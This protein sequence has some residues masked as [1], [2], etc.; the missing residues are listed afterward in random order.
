MLHAGSS[1][2][3]PF[4]SRRHRGVPDSR[5]L[6]QR[7]TAARRTSPFSLAEVAIG[8][9]VRCG[10]RCGFRPA[11]RGHLSW[12]TSEEARRP[13]RSFGPA[14]RRA[15]G[16][17]HS[18]SF[19]PERKKRSCVLAALG[20]LGGCRQ[21]AD[22]YGEEVGLPARSFKPARTHSSVRAA[23]DHKFSSQISWKTFF[24]CGVY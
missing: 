24:L 16:L 10:E 4:S 14:R 20:W 9:E 5:P 6:L 3:R 17:L 11:R 15:A 13:G 21:Q 8:Q 2:R 19:S 1:L 23:V 12:V 7:A 22:K 18:C